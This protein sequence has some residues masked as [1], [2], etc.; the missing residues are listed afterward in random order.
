M[1]KDYEYLTE[2]SDAFFYAAM[3]RLMLGRL[4]RMTTEAS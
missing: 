1:S 4:S 2:M 3:V